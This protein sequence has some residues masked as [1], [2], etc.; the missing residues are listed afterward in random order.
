ML[1]NYSWN[2]SYNLLI[3]KVRSKS[4]HISSL[5]FTPFIPWAL[6]ESPFW[7]GRG[8]DQIQRGMK[9][10]LQLQGT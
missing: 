7:E 1:T 2:F 4:E 5:S 6:T 8:E 3:A 10:Y 9:H